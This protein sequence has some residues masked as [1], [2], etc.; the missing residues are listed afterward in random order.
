MVA[1]NEAP[2]LFR[3]GQRV[4]S[5]V[6]VVV[7]GSLQCHLDRPTAQVSL[8]G[9]CRPSARCGIRYGRL[10]SV[11]LRRF[12]SVVFLGLSDLVRHPFGETVSLAALTILMQCDRRARSSSTI[13]TKHDEVHQPVIMNLSDNGRERIIRILLLQY[14][15]IERIEPHY[16]TGGG[17][18]IEASFECRR[19][20]ARDLSGQFAEFFPGFAPV[21]L[22]GHDAAIRQHL[23]DDFRQA[24][25]R[26]L[27]AHGLRILVTARHFAGIRST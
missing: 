21:N 27:S 3:I 17:L 22:A 13:M 6:R 19:P 18:I 9:G 23:V 15:V 5:R 7:P 26:D 16:A 14:D 25:M 12:E 11:N 4:G 20:P 8:F 10:I 1:F 2:K 24:E